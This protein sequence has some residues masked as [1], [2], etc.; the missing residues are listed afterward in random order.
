MQLACFCVPPSQPSLGLN[1]TCTWV[2]HSTHALPG[3]DLFC[4]VCPGNSGKNWMCATPWSAL[5]SL[6]LKMGGTAAFKK[7]TSVLR[8][9]VLS[10]FKF[11][12]GNRTIRPCRW[13]GKK[14]DWRTISSYLKATRWTFFLAA[15]QTWHF[16]APQVGWGKQCQGLS[17][18][19]FIE[20]GIAGGV[21][22]AGK[23]A[24]TTLAFI[25]VRSLT[26]RGDISYE[27]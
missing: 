14:I 17:L 2:L 10:T 9:P 11:P 26:C 1:S 24:L 23:G 21:L 5:C 27:S 12:Q 6:S 25:S 15:A 20:L 19:D 13:G 16:S 3:T 18:P 22:P 7:E 4:P 8:Y